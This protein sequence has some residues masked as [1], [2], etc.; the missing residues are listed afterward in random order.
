VLVALVVYS[1]W[2][3]VLGS[4]SPSIVV[5]RRVGVVVL[6]GDDGDFFFGRHC[7]EVV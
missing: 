6:V 4:G 5:L 2:L 3:F 1:V 7:T